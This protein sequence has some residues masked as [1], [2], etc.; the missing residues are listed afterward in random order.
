[1][2]RCGREGEP[3]A[4][5]CD[6][7]W[8]R[9]RARVGCRPAPVFVDGV[10]RL[11]RSTWPT[12]RRLI[13]RQRT[14]CAVRVGVGM[15]RAPSAREGEQAASRLHSTTDIVRNA[16]LI[17]HQAALG[18]ARAGP[19]LGGRK[20]YRKDADQPVAARSRQ[21]TRTTEPSILRPAWLKH[22]HVGASSG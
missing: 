19:S 4:G 6:R 9:R 15:S 16:G 17:R 8:P 14:Q 18:R 7:A 1:M 11:A 13:R 3:D 20:S 12:V 21:L 2:T 10:S 5:A 22:V